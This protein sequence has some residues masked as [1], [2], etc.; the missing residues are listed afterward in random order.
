M[1]GQ[2]GE[3][4]DRLPAT[5]ARTAISKLGG[6]FI[7]GRN[8]RP[9]EERLVR[10]AM[11]RQVVTIGPDEPLSHAAELLAERDV[12]VLAVCGTDH[13]LRAMITDR[14]IVVR[15]V[16]QGLDPERLTAGECATMDPVSVSPWETLGQAARQMDAQQ[17]RR[18]PVVQSGRLVGIVSQADLAASGADQQAGRLLA[19]LAQPRGDGRSARWLLRRSYR[20]EERGREAHR[21]DA[22]SA[23]LAPLVD[24]PHSVYLTGFAVGIALAA[25]ALLQLRPPI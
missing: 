14:D 19:R 24:T 17:V 5:R 3:G 25:L 22:T 10:D 2:I 23:A 15:S 11:S 1:N 4:T 9:E 18:L 13:R 7:G 20:E 8:S 16:A 6:R 12:G 21:A